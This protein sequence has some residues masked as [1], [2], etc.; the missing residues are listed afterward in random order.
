MNLKMSEAHLY[1]KSGQYGRLYVIS[2]SQDTYSPLQV[3]VL[4]EGLDVARKVSCDM[5]S[6]KYYC[7]RE[8]RVLRGEGAVPVYCNNHWYREGK[9]QEDFMKLYAEAKAHEEAKHKAEIARVKSVLDS[10]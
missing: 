4:P 7:E 10:Y 5:R 6:A 1:V 8:R 2:N 3:F 9:W